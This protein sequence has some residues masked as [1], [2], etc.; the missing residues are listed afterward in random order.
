MAR[1]SRSP[2][3]WSRAAARA[4]RSFHEAGGRH[5]DLHVGNL[6][7][8]D[9]GDQSEVVVVDLDR[10]RCTGVP[11]PGRRM[12]ELMRLYRSLRKR[13][14]LESA[15]PELEVA[16][17]NEYVNGDRALRDALLR[18]LPREQRRIARHAASWRTSSR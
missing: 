7:L 1:P 9:S 17:F 18:H 10:A 5:A 11:S 4:I 15:N 6:V 2:A 3:T 13:A 16:F 8:R 14:L 12:R